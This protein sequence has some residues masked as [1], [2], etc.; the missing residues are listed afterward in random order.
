M[1]LESGETMHHLADLASDP[2]QKSDFPVAQEMLLYY[3][4]VL[5]TTKGA[6]V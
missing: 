5:V 4:F 6:L 2:E 3:R 1:R